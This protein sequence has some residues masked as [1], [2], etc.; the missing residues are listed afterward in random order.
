VG[1]VS[2][3]PTA[4]NFHESLKK[5][6]FSDDEI[7]A[8]ASLETFGEFNDPKRQEVSNWPRLDNYL[9]K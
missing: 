9:Y 3:I 6:G 1:D 2:N 4:S 7:V 5:R 8:L